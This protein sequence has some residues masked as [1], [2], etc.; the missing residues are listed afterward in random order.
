MKKNDFIVL[1]NNFKEDLWLNS[2]KYII[3]Q[4][5]FGFIQSKQSI[6]AFI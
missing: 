6:F 2:N 1:D 3:N 4:H 5:G